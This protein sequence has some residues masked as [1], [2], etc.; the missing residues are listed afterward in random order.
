MVPAKYAPSGHDAPL[1]SQDWSKPETIETDF[2]KGRYIAGSW[3]NRLVN[4]SN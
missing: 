2:A 4:S 1:P 3:W